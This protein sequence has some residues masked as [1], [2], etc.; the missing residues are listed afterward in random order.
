MFVTECNCD[1][2]CV[3]ELIKTGVDPFSWLPDPLGRR[4]Q[5]CKDQDAGLRAD[6]LTSAERQKLRRLR[7]DNMRLRVE[8]EILST[9][10]NRMRIFSSCLSRYSKSPFSKREARVLQ[11]GSCSDAKIATAIGAPAGHRLLMGDMF[12]IGAAAMPASALPRPVDLLEPLDRHLF[13]REL[14]RQAHQTDSTRLRGLV[15]HRVPRS[16]RGPPVQVKRASSKVPPPQSTHC[17][18]QA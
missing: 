2:S 5:R 12:C 17:A 15:C 7:R 6:G 1:L 4:T 3:S 18:F 8:R 10:T 9:A 13:V 16:T 11:S 14:V